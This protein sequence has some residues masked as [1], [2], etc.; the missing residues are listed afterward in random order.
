M[1]VAVPPSL[2]VSFTFP[3]R[4]W[5]LGLGAAVTFI[6]PLTLPLA[7]LRVIQDWSGVAVQPAL[8]VMFVLWV[9]PLEGM[10]RLEGLA[11]ASMRTKNPSERGTTGASAARSRPSSVR[12]L[13]MPA[14]TKLPVLPQLTAAIASP[15]FTNS[16]A[17]IIEEN[18]VDGS[19][20]L[21]FGDGYVEIADTKA[22]DG[23]AVGVAS[24]EAGRSG[25]PD[26]WKRRRLI[27]AGA[28]LVVPDYAEA[29]KLVEWLWEGENLA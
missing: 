22:A 5:G 27:G 18:R 24:D 7:G 9:P 10:A 8:A 6:T 23:F 2:P 13:R 29:E 25:L 16:I 3:L 20:L 1:I 11:P 21:A 14:A 17:R 15:F 19:R 12:S 28:D 26:E 4:G